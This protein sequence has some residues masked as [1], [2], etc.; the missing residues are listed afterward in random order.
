MPMLVV[1][2]LVRQRERD[3]VEVEPLDLQHYSSKQVRPTPITCLAFRQSSL[4]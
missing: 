2:V 3:P 4:W 1:E